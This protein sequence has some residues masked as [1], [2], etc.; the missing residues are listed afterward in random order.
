M[1]SDY[2]H[3]IHLLMTTLNRLY[4]Y[5]INS[6]TLADIYLSVFIKLGGMAVLR[7][8][9]EYCIAGKAKFKRP[10]YDEIRYI[11][12]LLILSLYK[13]YRLNDDYELNQN[14]FAFFSSD[15]IVI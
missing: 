7:G 11:V 9:Q 14:P 15:K 1:K 2:H 5:M 8:F 3:N 4:F 12:S 6:G 10:D 13:H